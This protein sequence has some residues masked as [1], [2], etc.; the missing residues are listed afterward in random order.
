M[1]QAYII[2]ET[3]MKSLFDR[4]ELQS[5]RDNNIAIHPDQ[6]DKLTPDERNRLS[7]MHRAFHFVCVRWSQEMGFSGVRS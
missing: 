5:M 2:T 1:A 3:K 7:G 4:L 6:W